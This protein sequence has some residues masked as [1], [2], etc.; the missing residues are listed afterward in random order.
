MQNIDSER[1]AG[2][3]RR[4]FGNLSPDAILTASHESISAWDSIG[5]ITLLNLI[6]EEFRIDIDDDE[7][8]NSTS[9]SAILILIQNSSART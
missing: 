4:A 1:L 5:H 6:R 9:F 7:F 8:D 2:C 3:F